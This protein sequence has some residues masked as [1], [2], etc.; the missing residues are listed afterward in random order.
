[1]GIALAHSIVSDSFL[2]LRFRHRKMKYSIL[3]HFS[4]AVV[5]SAA[6]NGQ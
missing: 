2:Y 4:S 6:D 3:R 5:F 1:M